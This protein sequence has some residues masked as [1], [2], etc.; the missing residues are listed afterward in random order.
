MKEFG[1]LATLATFAGPSFRLQAVTDS[2]VGVFKWVGA[3]SAEHRESRRPTKLGSTS[4]GIVLRPQSYLELSEG[5]L[6]AAEFQ[7]LVNHRGLVGTYVIGAL[8]KLAGTFADGQ[9][10]ENDGRRSLRP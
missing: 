1:T 9:G 6:A 2:L 8:A 5:R 4:Q 7:K 10:A 3:Y